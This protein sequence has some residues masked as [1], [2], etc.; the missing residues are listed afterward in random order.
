MKGRLPCVCEQVAP[1]TLSIFPRWWSLGILSLL[2]CMLM[3]S[4]PA[5]LVLCC[6]KMYVLSPPEIHKLK[7]EIYYFG[8]K[9]KKMEPDFPWGNPSYVSPQTHQLA[10]DILNSATWLSPWNTDKNLHWWGTLMTMGY[11]LWFLAVVCRKSNNHDSCW[12]HEF[13]ADGFLGLHVMFYTFCC[14]CFCGWRVL[15]LGFW[16]KC[17]MVLLQPMKREI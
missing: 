2:I 13:K 9:N 15:V 7:W 16:V 17:P 4:L 3:I 1:G 12:D 8:F 6:S 11:S 14:L 10:F 5:L